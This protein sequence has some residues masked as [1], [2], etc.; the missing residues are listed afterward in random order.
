MYMEDEEGSAL[1]VPATVRW[2]LVLS[3][4]ATIGWGLFPGSLLDLASDALP[5]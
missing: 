2:V 3:V 5:L 4:A 1:V